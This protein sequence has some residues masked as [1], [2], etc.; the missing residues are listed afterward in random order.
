MMNA[1]KESCFPEQTSLSAIETVVPGIARS[2]SH[3]LKSSNIDGIFLTQATLEGAFD[4]RHL[5]LGFRFEVDGVSLPYNIYAVLVASAND[6]LAWFDLTNGCN[7]PGASIF[8]RGKF[9]LPTVK[10][11]AA[12]AL[13]L[14]IIVWG[15]L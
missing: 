6:V 14:H 1:A 12:G 4:G 15:R 2:F 7:G 9:D 5:N 3:R 10:F 8:P 11:E 13:D